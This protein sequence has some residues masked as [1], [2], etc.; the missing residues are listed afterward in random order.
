MMEKSSLLVLRLEGVLQSWGENAKWDDRG[1]ASMPSKSGIVGMLAC[2]MGLNRDD[3]EI[4]N[5][6]KAVSVTVRADRPGVKFVDFQTVTGDPLRTASGDKRRDSKGQAANTF[7]SRRTYLQDASFL[8]VIAAEPLWCDR[9]VAALKAPRWCL[10]LGRKNCVPSRPILEC[11][12]ME[13]SDPLKLIRDFPVADRSVLPLTF[14]TDVPLPGTPTYTRPD[15]RIDGYR[16][17]ERRPLWCGILEEEP[18]VSDEN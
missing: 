13:E 5:L 1:S 4:S 10:Y 8:V 6:S 17:F 15:E 11:K 9:I 18:H 14:E 2:A 16:S 3:P 7:I 12:V